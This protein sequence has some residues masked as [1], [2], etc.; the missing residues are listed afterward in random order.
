[1]QSI[2]QAMIDSY[3]KD[4]VIE[5]LFGVLDRLPTPLVLKNRDLVSIYVNEANA[6]FNGMSVEE[7]IGIS[8]FDFH[9]IEFAEEFARDDRE[10]LQSGN[11][12]EKDEATFDHAGRKRHFH[13]NK[14]RVM[15]GEDEAIILCTSQDMTRLRES[16]AEVSTFEALVTEATRAMDQGLIV[17]GPQNLMYSNE[18]AAKILEMPADLVA[19]GTVVSDFL[20]FCRNRGDFGSEVE[21]ENAVNSI[22][23]NLRKGRD[24]ELDCKIGDERYVRVM[25]KGRKAGGHVVTYTDVTEMRKRELADQAARLDVENAHALLKT[26]LDHLSEAIVIYDKDDR[27]VM[28]NEANRKLYP[29]LAHLYEPG[30]AL[31]DIIRCGVETGQWKL[32]PEERESFIEERI[33]QHWLPVH[34]MRQHLADG[35]WLLVRDQRTEN[36]LFVGMRADITEMVKREEQLTQSLKQNEVFR[37]LVD[38]VPISLYAKTE[39]RKIFY[40]NQGWSDLTGVPL[41][42][43]IGHTDEELMGADGERFAQDDIAIISNLETREILE[44][45]LNADGSTRYQIARKRAVEASDGSI[46]LIGSTTDVTDVITA[47]QKAQLSEATLDSLAVACLVKDGDLKYRLV[48]REFCAIVGKSGE[49]M[50]GKSAADIFSQSQ[51]D[52]FEEREREVL[53]TGVHK[54]FE[55]VVTRADGAKRNL[56]TEIHRIADENGKPAICIVLSDMTELIQAKEAAEIAEKAKSE[57]LANMSHEIR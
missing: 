7:C 23:E 38:N 2:R 36:G 6:K 42:K 19:A 4:A 37:S 35:R 44:T 28:C 32:E 16:E 55:E 30:M 52:E 46:H 50:I 9:P 1:M 3:G 33:R 24:Y 15:F 17:F 11:P 39:D 57:F 51:A 13:T 22:S 25:A 14:E 43:A 21:A 45:A 27:F 20:D 29:H 47:R 10:L 5:L 18:Q 12:V 41:D 49:E 8:D 40:A 54:S 48:N 34:E 56:K 53:A 31:A 26:A